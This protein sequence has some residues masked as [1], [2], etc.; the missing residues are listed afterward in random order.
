M[1][2]C[3]IDQINESLNQVNK[4]IADI[5]SFSYQFTAL[6]DVVKVSYSSSKEERS[7][8]FYIYMNQFKGALLSLSY[9]VPNFIEED[10]E[11]QSIYNLYFM[12]RSLSEEDYLDVLHS[13]Q[14]KDVLN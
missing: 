8:D 5:G 11:F 9:G 2:N 7:I 3:I 4:L 10:D 1:T 13:V 12:M 14:L 6:F